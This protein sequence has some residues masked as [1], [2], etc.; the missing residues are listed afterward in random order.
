MRQYDRCFYEG[1]DERTRF[2]ADRV[3]D[4]VLDVLPPIR[5]CIDIGCGVGTWLAA[6]SDRGVEDIVGAEGDWLDPSMLAIDAER[7]RTIDLRKPIDIDRRFDLAISLEVAEHIT[8]AQGAAL[9]RALT[10]LADFVLFSAAVPCQGGNHHVNE[11][12][13]S[14][15]G[16]QFA[17]LGFCAIDTIRPAIWSDPRIDV[18][19]RQNIVLY[20]KRERVSDLRRCVAPVDP[21]SLSRVHPD[22]Y[23]RRLLKAHGFSGGLKSM[24]RALAGGAKTTRTLRR[25]QHSGRAPASS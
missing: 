25:A 17:D 14:Y 19:Y 3:M 23:T 24:M 12:W 10:E 6:I 22:L 7:F 13:Q 15:W 20:V 11:Q 16:R 8:D 5:S 1:L 9:V 4:L 2:A 21:E 18:W